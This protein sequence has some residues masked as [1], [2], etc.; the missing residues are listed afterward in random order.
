MTW[1]EPP[2]LDDPTETRTVNGRK[3]SLYYDGRRLRLVAWKTDRA[4]YWVSNTLL[5][6]LTNRQMLA[7]AGSLRRLGA[8]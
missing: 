5:R 4:V 6:K 3:L 1:R 2:V 7:I 8:K